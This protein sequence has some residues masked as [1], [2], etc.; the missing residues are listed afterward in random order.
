MLDPNEDDTQP[1][2]GTEQTDQDLTKKSVVFI[3]PNSD[4][5]TNFSWK[6]D[7]K[8]EKIPSSV[9]YNPLTSYIK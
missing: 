5:S 2:T 3:E 1:D 7:K 6:S 9:V 4:V 8:L